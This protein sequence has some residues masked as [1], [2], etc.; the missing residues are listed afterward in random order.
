[1]PPRKKGPTSAIKPGPDWASWLNLA[2]TDVS[3]LTEE[4]MRMAIGLESARRCVVPVLEQ[5]EASK[6][7][8]AANQ[9]HPSMAEPIVVEEDAEI[10]RKR[11]KIKPEDPSS[12]RKC[13]KKDCENNF[14]CFN[15]LGL[16]AV[17]RGCHMRIRRIY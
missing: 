8:E 15:H 1:M 6:R 7:L 11:R 4:H 3:E 10:G 9:S 17:S 14:L 5:E 12:T 13:R 16:E 2:V